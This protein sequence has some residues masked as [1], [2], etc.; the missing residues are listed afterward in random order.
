[1]RGGIGPDSFGGTLERNLNFDQG[2]TVTAVPPWFRYVVGAPK[3]NTSRRGANLRKGGEDYGKSQRVAQAGA[4]RA[5]ALEGD[6]D[7]IED[8]VGEVA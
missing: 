2:V 1:M 3:K 5:S 7:F 6:E 8:G 4:V